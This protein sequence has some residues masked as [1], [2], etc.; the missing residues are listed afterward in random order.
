M[1]SEF[2][3]DLLTTTFKIDTSIL[4]YL[5][6]LLETQAAQNFN[7][8]CHLTVEEI[9]IHWQFSATQLERCAISQR[10]RFGH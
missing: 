5:P 3:M 7:K 9:S 8:H 10:K 4:F 2:E 1:I 6:L